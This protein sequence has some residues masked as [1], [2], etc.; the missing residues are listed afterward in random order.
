MAGATL[1]RHP[2]EVRAVCVNCARTDLRGGRSSMGV[3]TAT[4]IKFFN[5]LEGCCARP[6][7]REIKKKSIDGKSG[8][9]V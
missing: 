9:S 3:P 1:P 5:R 2:P 8:Q 6:V 4:E 7:H